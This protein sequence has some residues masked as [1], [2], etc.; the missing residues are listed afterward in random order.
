MIPISL[1]Y[2]CVSQAH[3]VNE[4][5]HDSQTIVGARGSRVASGFIRFSRA[6]GDSADASGLASRISVVLGSWPKSYFDPT[7]YT[8]LGQRTKT[9][10]RAARRDD[11][12]HRRMCV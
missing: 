2:Y 11:R 5:I 6:N 10:S 8:T 3:R 12:P 7:A 9:I 1:F 4:F